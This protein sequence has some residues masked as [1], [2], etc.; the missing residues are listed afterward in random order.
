MIE[1]EHGFLSNRFL[2]GG[3]ITV[4]YLVDEVNQ[5]LII[6]LGEILAFEFIVQLWSED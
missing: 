5:E 1:S 6:L 2:Q 4:P 3:P